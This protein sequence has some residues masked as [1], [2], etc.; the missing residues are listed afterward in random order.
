MEIDQI[1]SSFNSKLAN[2]AKFMDVYDVDL[3]EKK[4]SLEF[5]AFRH[6]LSSEE[7]YASNEFKTIIDHQ[8]LELKKLV[9]TFLGRLLALIKRNTNQTLILN[10]QSANTLSTEALKNVSKTDKSNT[11]VYQNGNP[12]ESLERIENA[13]P[14]SATS[15][16]SLNLSNATTLASPITTTTQTYT[17]NEYTRP[18]GNI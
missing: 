11:E 18:T 4:L 3:I 12:S 8:K 10:N 1:H 17:E 6:K 16:I 2:L 13:M 5:I 15:Q 7:T 14:E 9:D